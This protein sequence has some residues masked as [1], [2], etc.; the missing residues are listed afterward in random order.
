[1]YPEARRMVD[2]NDSFVEADE[3]QRKELGSG[4]RYPEARAK[5]DAEDAKRDA[6]NDGS[7]AESPPWSVR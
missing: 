4:P 3:R 6:L 7:R 1:M 5:V 2:I